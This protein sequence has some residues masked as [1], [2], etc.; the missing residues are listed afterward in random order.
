VANQKEAIMATQPG[1]F[2]VNTGIFLIPNSNT[3]MFGKRIIR[4]PDTYLNA[5]EK[6]KKLFVE[7]IKMSSEGRN[8][9]IMN[10]NDLE[11]EVQ[12]KFHEAVKSIPPGH[13]TEKIFFMIQMAGIA[14]VVIMTA[15]NACL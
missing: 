6:A 10:A 12:R 3:Y 2:G 9:V 11:K 1:A 13:Y 8:F 15:R 5:S 7:A 14:F 4:L